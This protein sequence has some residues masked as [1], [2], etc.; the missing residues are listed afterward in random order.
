[1]PLEDVARIFGD[2]DELARLEESHKAVDEELQEH[3]LKDAADVMHNENA[4]NG[5]THRKEV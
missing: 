4:T 3:G 2:D 1:M 5:D